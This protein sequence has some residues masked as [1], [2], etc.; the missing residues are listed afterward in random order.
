MNAR[1]TWD[2]GVHEASELYKTRMVGTQ[3]Q[4]TVKMRFKAV[5][6]LYMYIYL[7]AHSWSLYMSCFGFG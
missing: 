1:D 6:A 7:N 5:Y 4:I 2:R 3:S